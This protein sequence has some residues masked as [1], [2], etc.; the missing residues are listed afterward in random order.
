MKIALV[1][2]KDWPAL[3]PEEQPLIEL[4]LQHRIQA[5]PTIWDDS[6]VD[7]KCFDA[8][9]I[10]ST[11]DYHLH[12]DRFHI[13]LDRLERSGVPVWNPISLLRMSAEKTYLADIA[14]AGFDTVPSIFISQDEPI[15]INELF[16]DLRCEEAVLKPTVAASG[17]RA[18]RVSRCDR[19]HGHHLRELLSYG[20]VMAQPF[21][22]R[23]R[24]SGEWSLVYLGGSFSHGV[25]KRPARDDFR[26]QEELGG[27]T[28]AAQ[29]SAAIRKTC[30]RLIDWLGAPTLYARIDG[31]PDPDA[32]ILLSEVEL[33]EPLLFLSHAPGSVG[34]FAD[35]IARRVR[36]T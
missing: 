2:S 22:P 5:E 20:D 3:H 15:E 12:A 14:R 13:W 1:T 26:V 29:P 32:G 21:L 17:L 9:V 10:R 4:L 18:R 7:W 36:S 35:A 11:W 28:M 24:E 16:S 27:T 34:K 8:I 23:V 25:L 19:H 31:F 30:D 6:A 33:V